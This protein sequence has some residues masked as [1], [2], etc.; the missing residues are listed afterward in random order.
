MNITLKERGTERERDRQ[1][2]RQTEEQRHRDRDRPI[3]TNDL[4][5][6]TECNAMKQ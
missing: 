4:I 1:T 6:T 5:K 2:D 3:G